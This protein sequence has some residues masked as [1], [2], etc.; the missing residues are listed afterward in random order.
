MGSLPEYAAGEVIANKYVVENPL[1]SSPVGRTYQAGAGLGS[2]RLVVKIYRQDLSGRLMSA[3]D[4]FLKAGVATEIEHDNLATSLD[5]QEEMGHVFV[6]RALVEGEDFEDWARKHRK[7][8]NYFTRG[9]ELLWQACQGLAALHERFR[10]LNIHPGNVLVSPLVAKLADWDPRAL[11]NTEMTPEPLPFRAEFAGYRAPEMS[12]RGSFLSYPST[13]LFAV[14]GL[15]FRL[16]K[17]RHPDADLARTHGEFRSLEGDLAQFLAKAMHPRPEE[18]FQEAASFSDALWELQ[19]AMQRLQERQSRGGSPEPASAPA[20]KSTPTLAM[21]AREPTLFGSGPTP[22]QAAPAKDDDSFFNFFPSAETAPARP[23]A[24]SRPAPSFPTSRPSGLETPGEP[25]APR[26]VPSNETLFGSSLESKAAASGETLFGDPAPS[27]PSAQSARSDFGGL[28]GLESS[29]TLFGAEPEPPSPPPRQGRGKSSRPQADAFDPEPPRAPARQPAISLS[30]LEKDPLELEQEQNAGGFT[31]F[32][33]K[34][35]GDNRTLY[36]ESQKVSAQRKLVIGLAVLGGVILA[37]AL[38][39]LFVFM[40]TTAAPEVADSPGPF[41]TDDDVEPADGTAPEVSPEPGPTPTPVAEPVT[42]R[43]PYPEV[44]SA[45]AEVPPKPVA[46][47][48]PRPEKPEP[49]S[50]QA[51]APK[52]SPE[53]LAQLMAMVDTREWPASAAARI[54]AA[55]ELNDFGKIAEANVVYGRAMQAPG[56]TDRQK[57]TALGGLAATFHAMGMKPQ[58]LDA[59]NQ[60]LS[61]QPG[62]SFAIKFRDRIK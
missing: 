37:L 11:G 27:R 23:A 35:A 22:A 21:D 57:V 2:P 42:A 31:Q 62:N 41:P 43:P 14:A 48:T 26:P 32:G 29:G 45:E 24:A 59:L 13:D 34:G 38:G 36:G 4:F 17:G 16:V 18:R 53:R 61:I 49:K 52:G 51:P 10:H 54:Q 19:P 39:G 3:P 25:P 50:A 56:A 1:G 12:S 6:A 8:A 46:V 60:I 55:D 40:R 44:E 20:P 7:D 58:A 47:S 28:A 5:V 33:F 9:L 30:A 15:L